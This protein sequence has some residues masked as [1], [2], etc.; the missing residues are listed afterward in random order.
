MSCR[1]GLCYMGLLHMLMLLPYCCHAG[2][3]AYPHPKRVDS[4]LLRAFAAPLRV[5]LSPRQGETGQPY[6]ESGTERAPPQHSML[7]SM[8]DAHHTCTVSQR[9]WMAMLT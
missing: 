4:V 2:T 9:S 5:T 7:P 1:E 8:P 3:C 6:L